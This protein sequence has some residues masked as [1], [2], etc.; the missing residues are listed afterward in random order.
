MNISNALFL[1]VITLVLC[2]VVGKIVDGLL[3]LGG[4][5]LVGG[6]AIV[7]AL[8]F[9][10]LGGAGLNMFLAF[11]AVFILYRVLV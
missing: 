8:F 2:W 10:G 5:V 11:C 3:W 6:L 9:L 1:I 7:V 4:P